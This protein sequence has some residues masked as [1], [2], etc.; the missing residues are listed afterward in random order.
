MVKSVS[1]YKEWIKK[2]SIKIIEPQT[3]DFE[4]DEIDTKVYGNVVVHARYEWHAG[5]Y[6]V[7]TPRAYKDHIIRE[8]KIPE[9]LIHI[10]DYHKILKQEKEIERA[11]PV[12]ANGYQYI[13]YVKVWDW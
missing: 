1:S 7:M 12:E 10:I 6:I 3:V 8:K 13:V 11:I 5:D 2:N 9:D 4:K